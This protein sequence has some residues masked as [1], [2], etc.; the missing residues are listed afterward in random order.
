MDSTY[1]I[2]NKLYSNQKG[3]FEQYGIDLIIAI[4]IIY[5]FL[6]W[7][8]YFYAM[9][10]LPLLRKN[11]TE[12]KCNPLYIP[13]AGFILDDKTKSN[14]EVV[15]NN[16]SDCTQNILSSIASDAFKPIYFIMHT[17]T[18]TFG[19]ISKSINGVR[20]MLN[21]VRTDIKDTAV[22][23]SNRSLN[24]MAPITQNNINTASMMG[25]AHG[26]LTTSVY[27]LFGSFITAK[28]M[29][30]FLKDVVIGLLLI[31]FASLVG[32]WIMAA[33]PFVDIVALP[34][35]MAASAFYTA[36]LIPFLIVIILISEIFKVT[37]SN[38]PKGPPGRH[39]CFDKNTLIKMNDNNYKAIS[40][41]IIGDIL[42][43][44]SIITGT[45]IMSTYGNSIYN[46]NNI[47]VTGL[48]RI[49]H[50]TKGW[51]KV[52]DHPDAYEIKDYREN[53][54][55]CLNTNTKVI[56]INN[57]T[58]S[59]WDDLDDT[60]IQQINNKC[61]FI[62]KYIEN[63]DIHK[64]FDNGFEENT[65]I[66]MEIGTFTKIKDIEVNDILRFG[67]RVLGIIKID[68]NDL[69]II[70]EYKLNNN[71]IIKCTNNI[72]LF[73]Y[74]LGNICTNKL[75]GTPINIKNNLYQLITDKGY[76]HI[77]EL[78]VYD[79]N[80]AIEK[81]LDNTEFYSQNYL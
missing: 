57:H 40:D 17:L 78:R 31:L 56:K 74:N 9:N 26:V 6:I 11:W 52:L 8:S 18:E 47:I 1:Q 48:H 37:T 33:I 30:L 64:Y 20:S 72:E 15:G 5:I 42:H 53:M 54:V 41:I 25:K 32:L 50:E 39:A 73:N 79:Y 71:A 16:F 76:Y 7:T 2:I 68:S 21:N 19:E 66:E 44:G 10:H 58:F 59:D 13:L 35:A 14:M 38:V 28:S 51:I 34:A 45:M 49:Y 55:Y 65:L 69:S 23:I 61:T 81:Y 29:F 70:N 75:D 3:F 24:V 67:E 12:N 43:D 60:D 22:S 27:T 80:F 36:I 46:F 4:V 62:S 63:D 77:G